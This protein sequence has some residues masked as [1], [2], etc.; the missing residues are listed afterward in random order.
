MGYS[1]KSRHPFLPFAFDGV[2]LVVQDRLQIDESSSGAR[3]GSWSRRLKGQNVVL[4]NLSLADLKQ[5]IGDAKAYIGLPLNSCP[6][7]S[8]LQQF[9]R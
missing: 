9:H 7:S 5:F 3:S 1:F 8:V 2:N 6:F 4:L